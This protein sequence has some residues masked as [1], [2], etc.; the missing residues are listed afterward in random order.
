[1]ENEQRGSREGKLKR[2]V[3]E[4]REER[5]NRRKRLKCIRLQKLPS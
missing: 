3:A 2:N 1:M 5:N 4:S